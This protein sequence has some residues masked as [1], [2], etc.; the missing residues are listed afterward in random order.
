MR[1]FGIS[2]A[3]SNIATLA[4]DYIGLE[5]HLK[6][7]RSSV[8]LFLSLVIC[9]YLTSYMVTQARGEYIYISLF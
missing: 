9:L 5:R 2:S 3:L 7:P 6:Q 4:V 1:T 8:G